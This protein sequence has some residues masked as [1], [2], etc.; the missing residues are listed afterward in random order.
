VALLLTLAMTLVIG[1][2]A[3]PFIELAQGAAM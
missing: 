2:C 3:Q 1:V